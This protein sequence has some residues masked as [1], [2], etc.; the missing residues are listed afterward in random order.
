MEN[1]KSGFNN[2]SLRIKSMFKLFQLEPL[3]FK[4]FILITLLTTIIFS[5]SAFSGN[6]HYEGISKLA[7][8]LFFAVYGY[9]MKMNRKV[10]MIFYVLAGLCFVLGV[11]AF[12]NK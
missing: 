2:F 1:I 10:F 9:K 12:T 4:E 8:A 3:W 5:S 6:S 7:A 11:L